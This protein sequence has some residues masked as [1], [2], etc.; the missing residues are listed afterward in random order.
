MNTNTTHE[1]TQ[2]TR[3]RIHTTNSTPQTQAPQST[4]P[5]HDPLG[6]GVNTPAEEDPLGIH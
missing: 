6:L 4:D 1:R 2:H 3:T 5:D